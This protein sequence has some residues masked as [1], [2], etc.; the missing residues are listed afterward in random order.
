MNSLQNQICG[1]VSHLHSE[2]MVWKC[3][4]QGG[5]EGTKLSELLLQKPVVDL[6]G[7][8]DLLCVAHLQRGVG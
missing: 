5:C 1:L 8:L 7:V 4:L 3:S 6:R 2:W